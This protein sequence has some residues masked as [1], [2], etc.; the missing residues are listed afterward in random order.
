LLIG[1]FL[2]VLP[3]QAQTPPDWQTQVRRYADKKDWTSAM[4][5]VEEQ[6]AR[7]PGDFDVRAWR[8]RVLEWSG[9]LFEAE[10]E[11][12]Q[13]LQ[14]ANKDPDNWLGLGTVYL[15][16]GKTQEALRA[17][18]TAV[19]LD[20]KRADLRMAHGRALAAVGNR[21]DA[22][23]EFRR[24]LRLDPAN[25]EVRVAQKS[26]LGEPK[27]ELRVGQEDNAFNFLY[28]N[29]D[30]LVSLQTQWNRHWNTTFIGNFFQ[31]GPAHAGKFEASIGGQLPKWGGL[32]IG[33]AA[34]HD[35]G[36]LPKNEAFFELDHGWKTSKTGFARGLEVTYG[37]HW[38]WYRTAR[39]LALEGTG[40]LYLPRDWTFSI[41]VT[42]AQSHFAGLGTQ[43]RP[44][45][46]VRLGFP[47]LQGEEKQ[48][49][50][51]IFFGTGTE[52]FASIDQIGSFASQTFGAGLKFAI[53]VRQDISP[54]ASY[55]KRS[56]GKTDTNFG[57]SYGI[58]F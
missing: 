8:A 33:G 15:R 46:I 36:V 45:E 34:G 47:I 16:E 9:R 42:E 49:F 57:L 28:P 48:I 19:G 11:Y 23:L 52:D 18:D 3:V 14:V 26:I 51:N 39:V 13:I 54:Y 35:S 7:A 30:E 12:L 40:L 43:W 31:W 55:Q 44:S 58:R 29:Y 37:P 24:A 53:T 1:A 10:K 21:K 25:Q 32:T 2:V 50:G 38:Y 4:S 5:I 20:P 17:L 56:Q 6:I 22:Q 41:G 27:N